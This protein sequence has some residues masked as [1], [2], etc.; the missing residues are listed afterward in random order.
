[1]LRQLESEVL[2]VVVV[3]TLFGWQVLPVS[4]IGGHSEHL[5]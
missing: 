5:Q 3:I 4:A 1:M 2:S